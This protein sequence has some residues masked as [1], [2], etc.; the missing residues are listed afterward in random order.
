M[1]ELSAIAD[2]AASAVERG[3]GPDF[4]D[5]IHRTLGA[6]A[7][8]GDAA[9][10]PIVPDGFLA[11]GDLAREE[12]AAFCVSGAGGGDVAVFL[13]TAP[14]SPA[15]LERAKTLGLF[16]LPLDLDGK[17]VRVENPPPASASESSTLL[18]S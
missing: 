9:G 11:L 16:L 17:G 3:S 8:L 4:L 2:A 13:G 15:F 5:A 10:V 12:D 14:P 18:R 7:R 6:L 1:G